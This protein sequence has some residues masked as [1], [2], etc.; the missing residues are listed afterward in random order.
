MEDDNSE[1]DDVVRV[2]EEDEMSEN[3]E[4][5]SVHGHDRFP[6]LAIESLD[7]FMERHGIVDA[8]QY[9][10]QSERNL[11]E[12]R[13][14]VQQEL[15]YQQGI[16]QSIFGNEA[17]AEQ[18]D[19]DITSKRAQFLG[20]I[21]K[22]TI[23]I[24]TCKEQIRNVPLQKMAESCETVFA[25]ASFQQSHQE[26][27]EHAKQLTFSLKSFQ[28]E[29]VVE[30]LAIVLEDKKPEEVSA[31]HAVECCE[32]ARYMQCERVLEALVEILME[33]IDTSN[34]MSLCL[35]ADR[36]DLSQL[37]ERSMAQMIQSV[38][39]LQQHELWQ[40]FHPELRKRIMDMEKVM[41][42]SIHSNKNK[43]YFGSME[44]YLSIFCENVQYYRERLAEAKERQA[45]EPASSAGHARSWEYAQAKI[46]H[47]EA[48]LRTLE[49]VLKEQ[50]ELFG[51][52]GRQQYHSQSDRRL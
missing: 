35:L 3:E 21:R 40:D 44:E 24:K 19:D 47:Q 15:D 36:L 25:L 12:E 46:E 16:H 14:A 2:E 18:A 34:C 43:L 5:E 9:G 8:E 50:K 52:H 38:G 17:P 30:F 31:D 49:L 4:E 10:S 6:L 26:E 11:A 7:H 33:S 28:H 32:I 23:M 39:N 48:R 42:S 1:Y 51:N 41:K 27:E 22:E 29:A 45:Q 20:S 13:L 37:F